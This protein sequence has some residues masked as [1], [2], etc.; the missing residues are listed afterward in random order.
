MRAITSVALGVLMGAGIL[1]GQT[2]TPDAHVA[3][4]KAAAA[5]D[6]QNLFNFL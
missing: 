3:R 4:A 5:N 2:D 6:Y 1:A